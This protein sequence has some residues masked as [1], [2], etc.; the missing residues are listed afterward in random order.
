MAYSV[1]LL[2]TVA[3]CDNV[4]KVADEELR[5]LC[6]RLID[7]DYQHENTS[8]AAIDLT[9]ELTGL[10]AEI[11]FL[12]PLIAALPTGS[13]SRSKRET[14]L[15]RATDRRDELTDRQGARR[16]VALL[17]REL[18]YGQTQTHIT[19]TSSFVAA[20]KARKAAI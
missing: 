10:E 19:E 15:R 5:V 16:A 11:V 6:K 8:N 1:N 13:D 20:V 4:L 9:S 3:D 14:Q 7:F 17:S 12:T 2:T 18:A